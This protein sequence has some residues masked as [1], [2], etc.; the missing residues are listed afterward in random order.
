MKDKTSHRDLCV[1]R[2]AR[3]NYEILETLE[4]GIVLT[5]PEV[6]SL[7]NAAANL[8]DS[9]AQIR[10]S[11]IFL[12]N[13]HIS[14]YAQASLRNTDPTR[15]RKLLLHKREIMRLSS[16]VK[17]KGLTIIPLSIYLSG[18]LI[19]VNLGLAKGRKTH[20]KKEVLRERDVKREVARE[21]KSWR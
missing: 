1:N 7:R 18:S 21:V 2:K 16:K 17:E 12:H 5:G 15:I 20:D 10:G 19:K 6:K 4:A 11:E 14:P 8:K 13:L 3:H 9:F